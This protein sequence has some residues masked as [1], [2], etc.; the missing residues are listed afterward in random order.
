MI[1]PSKASEK[2][3]PLIVGALASQITHPGVHVT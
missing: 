2:L 3:P 1:V